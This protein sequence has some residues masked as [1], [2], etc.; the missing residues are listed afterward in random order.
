MSATGGEPVRLTFHPA[1]DQALGWTAEGK[2][3]FRSRRDTRT[4]TTAFTPSPATGGIPEHDSA[5]TGG[6]DFL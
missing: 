3:L 4:M 1:A 5:R 6:V 2:V